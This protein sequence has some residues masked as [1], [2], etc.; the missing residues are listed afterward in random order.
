[1]DTIICDPQLHTDFL[2]KALS[3]LAHDAVHAKNASRVRK[4]GDNQ[5]AWTS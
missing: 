2:A 1:M 4:Q 3:L 5:N